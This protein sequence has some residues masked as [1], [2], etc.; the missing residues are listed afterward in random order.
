[1]AAGGETAKMAGTANLVPNGPKKAKK[2]CQ[3]FLTQ[4]Y[5]KKS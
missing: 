2:F 3:I 5:L 4:K 1:M